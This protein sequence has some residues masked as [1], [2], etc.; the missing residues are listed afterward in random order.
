MK[1]T[2]SNKVKKPEKERKQ[3]KVKNVFK[4]RKATEE[5]ENEE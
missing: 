1:K 3:K 2:A 5:M 4:K